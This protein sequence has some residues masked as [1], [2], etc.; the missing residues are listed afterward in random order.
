MT[1]TGIGPLGKPRRG[2]GVGT[3]LIWM[4]LAAAAGAVGWQIYGSEVRARLGINQRQKEAAVISRPDANPPAASNIN[5]LTALVRDLQAVEQRNA[6]DIKTALQLLIAEQAA[7]KTLSDSVAL[8][9]AKVDALQ[10]PP[11]TPVAK[12]PPAASVA[13]KPPVAPPTNIVGPEPELEPPPGA[14]ASR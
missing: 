3:F 8:L 2:I 11:P 1:E 10:R 4:V 7:T 13:R 12:K 14:P 5:E 9:Q 6:E